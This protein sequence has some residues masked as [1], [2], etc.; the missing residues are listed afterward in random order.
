MVEGQSFLML[1]YFSA[2]FFSPLVRFN[3]GLAGSG[4][5]RSCLAMP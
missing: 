5:A 2:L 1:A 3:E 4:D